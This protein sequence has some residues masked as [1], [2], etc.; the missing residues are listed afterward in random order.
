MPTPHSFLWHDYE[1][2]GLDSRKERPTQFAAIRTDANLNEIGEP[3]NLICKLPDDIVPSAT[4]SLLTGIL[5]Q[6]C[7]EEG[8]SE[9][10]FA[11]KIHAEMIKP[12]TCVLGFNTLRFDDEF[13]RNLMYR[14]LRDPYEREWANGNTRWDIIDMV[15]TCHAFRPD[16]INW[17]SAEDGSTSFKLDDIARANNLSVERAHDA[18]SDVRTT[19]AVAKLI[20]QAQPK[21]FDHMLAL[22][23]KQPVLALLQDPARKPLAHVASAYG[24]ENRCVGLVVPIGPHPTNKNS[25]IVADLSVDPAEW[26]GLDAGEIAEKIQWKPFEEGQPRQKQFIRV[27]QANKCPALFSAS[28]VRDGG[29]RF[30][31]FDLGK[32]QENHQTILADTTLLHRAQT[33]ILINEEKRVPALDPELGIYSGFIGNQDKAKLKEV[34]TLSPEM[35]AGRRCGFSDSRLDTLLFRYRARNWP[36]TLGPEERAEWDEFCVQRLTSET[37]L[38]PRTINEFRAEIDRLVEN[39]QA[40]ADSQD[41]VKLRDFADQKQAWVDAFTAPTLRSSSPSP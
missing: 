32:I 17:P 6:K 38:G 9:A 39:G 2:T 20:R 3:I 21:L 29:D 33:A 11:R 34:L 15:R 5:P 22:R 26:L 10:E 24:K 16:G 8:I 30:S 27:I 36:E 23:E 19:I 40:T 7:Q 14:N 28:I 35:L 18:L 13:T 4:A 37:E 31:F 12:G 41:I 25:F 1:T